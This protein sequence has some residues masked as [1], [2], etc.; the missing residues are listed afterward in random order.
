MLKYTIATC[1]DVLKG[2][3]GQ[4]DDELVA[5]HRLLNDLGYSTAAGLPKSDSYETLRNRIQSTR[6]KTK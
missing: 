5:A 3:D 1:L 6:L 2:L 4:N